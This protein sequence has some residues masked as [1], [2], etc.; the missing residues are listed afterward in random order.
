MDKFSKTGSKAVS[1]ATGAI[2]A[3][4]TTTTTSTHS[5]KRVIKFMKERIHH[6]GIKRVSFMSLF[7][8]SVFL[9]EPNLVQLLGRMPNKGMNSKIWRHTWPPNMFYEIHKAIFYVSFVG[10]A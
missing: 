4:T 5:K 7:K 1:V 9:K 8:T 3:T 10:I 2:A 6:K